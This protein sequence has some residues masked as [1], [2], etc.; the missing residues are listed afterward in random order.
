MPEGAR[1]Y[2][3]PSRIH[4]GKFY[5]LAQSPQF[6]KQLFMVAGFDRY[7]QLARCLRDEDQRADRQPEHT[8]YDLE[9]SFATP[10]AVY[11]LVEGLMQSLFEK[12]AGVEVAVPFPR[13]PYAEA[14]AKYG[15]DKPDL[16]F[17]LELVD[18]S[19]LALDTDFGIFRSALGSGGQVKG[20]NATGCGG[21][22][23]HQI[24]ELEKLAQHL[25]AKGLI[26][27]KWS[28][29][30]MASP[31]AKFVPAEL[32]DQ[33]KNRGKV[34]A[35]DLLLL[36]ADKPRVCAQALGGLRNELARRL[37]LTAA[38]VYRFCWVVDFPLF[39]WNEEEQRFEPE[40]HIFTMPNEDDRQYLTT[41]PARV[42]GQLYDLVCNGWE[43]ASGSIRNHR[44]EVQEEVMAVIGMSREAARQQF[45]FLLEAFEYGA[46]PHG[47]IAGGI[48]RLVMILSG[49]DNIRDVIPFP[50]TLTATA[51]MEQAPSEVTERQLEELH[52]RLRAPGR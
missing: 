42:R 44:R 43:L 45:G 16:R 18:F 11:E 22:S 10:E 50:K 37:K 28:E 32:Q 12:V 48:D 25:G 9:M 6:Y 3:V 41:D 23:R 13:L 4:P 46:P 24:E 19:D 40:H 21:W 5:A 52:L 14:M 1:D 27:A 29:G 8:Q 36:I 30:K 26:W 51:L 35:G 17:E 31:I 49:R 34:A 38:N 33:W 7:Y 20:I 39:K 15:S 2:L 47:G